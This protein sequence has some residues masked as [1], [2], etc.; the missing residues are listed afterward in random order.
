[1][2]KGKLIS[3]V[4][5]NIFVFC[6]V[7]YSQDVRQKEDITCKQAYELIEKHKSDSNFVIIDFRPQEKYDAAHIQNALYLDVFSENADKWLSILDKEKTYLIYCT[8]GH[9]SK[10]ALKKMKDLDFKYLYHL[11]EGLATWEKE[12][13]EIIAME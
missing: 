2:L 4:I 3:F 9:R 7:L 10:I 13:Y 11:Y 6:A 8:I 1:M 5:L 12:G